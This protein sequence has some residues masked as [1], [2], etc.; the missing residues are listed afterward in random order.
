MR[1]SLLVF[2]IFLLF[3]GLAGCGTNDAASQVQ[4]VQAQ[5]I[6]SQTGEAIT[7]PRAIPPRVTFEPWENYEDVQVMMQISWPY[8]ETTSDLVLRTEFIAVVTV[9]DIEVFLSNA[10]TEADRPLDET[11]IKYTLRIDESIKGDFEQSSTVEVWQEGWQYAGINVWHPDIPPLEYDKTYLLFFNSAVYPHATLTIEYRFGTPFVA[12]PEIVDGKLYPH[13]RNNLISEGEPA[14]DMIASVRWFV[15]EEAARTAALTN[16]T[17]TQGAQAI[18]D[19]F[20]NDSY[21]SSVRD[22]TDEEMQ[23][24]YDFENDVRMLAVSGKLLENTDMFIWIETQ[25]LTRQ[26]REEFESALIPA[27]EQTA[28]VRDWGHRVRVTTYHSIIVIARGEDA[29]TILE[30]F[31]QILVEIQE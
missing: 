25:E 20:A 4:S 21:Q 5:P 19:Y 22:L 30:K 18:S 14:V 13:P 16:L 24:V 26:Q 8:F 29:A 23:A 7:T 2:V 28:S 15:E 11:L 6:L 31:R 10:N 17:A 12:Y 1:K 9:K 3:G 27:A